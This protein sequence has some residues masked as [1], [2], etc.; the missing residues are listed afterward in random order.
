MPG[1]L[2]ERNRRRRNQPAIPTTNLPAGGRTGAVPRPPK[3]VKLGTAGTAWW[4]WAW[5]TPQACGW[6]EDGVAD[7]VARRA[8]LEDDLA[9]LHTVE[10]L[11]ALEAMNTENLRDLVRRLAAILTGSLGI[12]RAMFEIDGKLGFTPK[13]FA[14]LRWTIVGESERGVSP[15]P[16]E[17]TQR[18]EDR[19]ARLSAS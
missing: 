13:G 2:P 7:V 16:D 11:D 15:E 17:V 5:H 3:W 10:S 18:R 14:D 12:K 8:S 9:A 1:P 19:R 4:R 6:V